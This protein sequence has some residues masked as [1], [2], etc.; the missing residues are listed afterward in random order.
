MNLSYYDLNGRKSWISIQCQTQTTGRRAG[1]SIDCG[2]TA[3][4]WICWWSGW[5]ADS[6]NVCSPGSRAGTSIWLEKCV[7]LGCWTN[8]SNDSETGWTGDE[9]TS[10]L[11]TCRRKVARQVVS[12]CCGG[13]LQTDLMRQCSCCSLSNYL[14]MGL[15]PTQRLR[16]HNTAHC[17]QVCLQELAWQVIFAFIFC[18]ADC[19][20]FILFLIHI[21]FFR[22]LSQFFPL[23]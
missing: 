17:S 5:K 22:L 6:S 7:L 10:E 3:W 1:R 14:K 12:C 9:L 11:M 4:K 15:F 18:L 20:K 23:N 13:D 8:R 19:W 16:H 2:R 21:K